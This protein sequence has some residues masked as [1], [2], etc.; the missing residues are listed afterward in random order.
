MKFLIT[1]SAGFVGNKTLFRL[2][3]KYGSKNNEFVLILKE[4]KPD[5]PAK[6]YKL[7]KIT[8]VF[9]DISDKKSISEYFLDVDY[10]FHLAAKLDYGDMRR[11]LYF[12]INVTGT[13]NVFDLAIANNVKKI[14]YL[15]SAAIHHPTHDRCVDELSELTP[16]HTTLYTKTKYLS[17]LKTLEY[18]KN[19]APIIGILPVSIYGQGS[20]LFEPFIG[21]IKKYRIAI[22]PKISS[23][24]SLVYVDDL[25]AG[26]VLAF[27]KSRI[28]ELYYFS[29][30]DL[31]IKEI[32]KKIGEVIQRRVYLV[33]MPVFLYVSMIKISD[34]FFRL[35]SKTSYYNFE[36]FEFISGGLL[37]S[38][39]KAVADLGYSSSNFEHN[40][41]KMIKH[42][43]N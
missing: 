22:I 17:Y 34:L 41:K 40:F 7:T 2:L 37:A 10:V 36:M 32:V 21:L 3:E 16:G 31:S 13:E 4:R 42:V 20:P 14:I 28:G 33:E 23:R 24:L 39:E 15:S 25:V 29:G 43:N 38:H 27:E 5:I 18:I 30:P 26:I 6:Y 8:E 9:G 11:E 12:S 35:F 19:G 1:G